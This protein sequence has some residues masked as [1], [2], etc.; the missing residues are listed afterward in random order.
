MFNVRGKFT[1]ISLVN[2]QH[3]SRN[4]E[5]DIW[6]TAVNRFIFKNIT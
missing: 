6:N 3:Q 4:L 2:E 5:L 1:W